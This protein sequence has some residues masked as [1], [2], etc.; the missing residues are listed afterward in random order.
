[1]TKAEIISRLQEKHQQFTA[2]IVSLSDADFMYSLHGEKWTAGQQM[3]HIRLSVSPLGMAFGLPKFIPRL[4]F[5]KAKRPSENYD[6]VVAKYRHALANGGIAVKGYAPKTIPLA[7]KAA[8]KT[9]TDQTLTHVLRRLEKYSEQDL[10]TLRLPHPL[11]GKLTL[12]EMLYFTL[13]H[14]QHHHAVTRR[15]LESA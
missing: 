11:L 3:D 14:V 12:R 9:Q 10:D 1:M 8:L 7:E 13:Y 2:Y 5:G 4:L 6:T 15:H